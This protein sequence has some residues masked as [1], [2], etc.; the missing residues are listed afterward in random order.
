[1]EGWKG[2]Q[3]KKKPPPSQQDP[4][5]DSKTQGQW[6]LSKNP[7]HTALLNRQSETRKPLSRAEITKKTEFESF[8]PIRCLEIALL[9][10]NFTKKIQK[11]QLFF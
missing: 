8:Q 9:V 6:N 4:C 11:S 1:M 5:Q 3:L 7:V 2:V 10:S